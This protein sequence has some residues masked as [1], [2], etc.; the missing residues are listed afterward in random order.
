MRWL[1]PVVL[2]MTV[3]RHEWMA[4]FNDRSNL[5][6]LLAAA[7]SCMT[8]ACDRCEPENCAHRAN[9]MTPIEFA[10]W[11]EE[12]VHRAGRAPLRLDH[13]ENLEG[14]QHRRHGLELAV[15]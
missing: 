3:P 9:L 5:A 10:E 1:V 14:G 15:G 8:D 6:D 11:V 7:R 4:T 12:Q 13:R 2:D